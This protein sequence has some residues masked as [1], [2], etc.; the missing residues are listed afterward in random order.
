MYACA[1]ARLVYARKR[2]AI[3]VFIILGSPAFVQA[4][5]AYVRMP[6]PARE[7]VRVCVRVCVV[8]MF[9]VCVCEWLPV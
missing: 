1:G 4:I 6:L 3:S 5:G 2:A 8:C 9:P 7:C